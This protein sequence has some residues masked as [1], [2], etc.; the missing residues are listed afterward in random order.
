MA[1]CCIG[2]CC[3]DIKALKLYPN[4]KSTA[5]QSIEDGI[6][7]MGDGRCAAVMT[8]EPLCDWW[9]E[10]SETSAF[11]PKTSKNQMPYVVGFG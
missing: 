9:A 8:D 11:L 7:A 4:L 10:R 3:I 1:C 5:V 2:S 6:T